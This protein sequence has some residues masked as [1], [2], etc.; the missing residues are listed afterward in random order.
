MS[1]SASG[2]QEY[3]KVD[4]AFV[5]FRT[6]FAFLDDN[7]RPLED[8]AA[9]RF[10]SFCG[11]HLKAKPQV[12]GVECLAKAYTHFFVEPLVHVASIT[13]GL[14]AQEVIKAITNRDQPL[15]NT[16]LFNAHTS[17]A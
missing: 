8:G 10:E 7:Q 2:L 16:V 11:S 13:G 1:V 5:L 3:P 12:T 9:A 15:L 14:L 6:F 4:P 17:V